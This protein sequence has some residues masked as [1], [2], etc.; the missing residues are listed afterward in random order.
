M[1]SHT[2]RFFISGGFDQVS[3]ETGADLL[4]L[5]DLDQKLWA[6]LS[7]PVK[8][9][10]FDLKTLEL[11]DSDHDGHIRAP[12][13][14]EAVTWA[15]SVLKDPE[16]LIKGS[17][18]IP[19]SAIN[20]KTDE[21]KGLLSSAQQ[22]LKNLGKED[23]DVISVEDTDSEER[24]FAQMRFNGDGV[25]TVKSAD[26]DAAGSVITDIID[27]L[28]ADTDRSGNPGVSQGKVEQFFAEIQ[29]YSEWQ[30]SSGNDAS[31]LIL[32][33]T[34]ESAFETLS[35]VRNKVNDYFTRCNLAK[36]D[37]RSAELL[38]PSD[39]DYQRIAPN[40]FSVSFESFALFPVAL[41][42]PDKPLPLLEEINPAW[43]EL[44][45][46]LKEDVVKPF[47]GDKT[48]LTVEEWD[49]INTHF[50]PYG[51]WRAAKPDTSVERLGTE[52]INEILNGDYKQLID[53]L[54]A[55]DKAFEPEAN[56]I[57]SVDKLV[58]YCRYLHTL[59]NNFVAFRDFYDHR[60]K[61][62]FQAGTLYLDG[63][64]CDLCVKVDDIGAHTALSSLSRVY[65]A[66]C[67]CT[68]CGGTDK[69]IVAAAFTAGDSDQLMVGRNGVF[70]DRKGQDWDATIVRII[71]HPISIK[72]A[73]WAP[74]KQA[75][76][77]IS[78]QL[79]KLAAA[80]SRASEDRMAVS[81]MQSGMQT[82]GGKP[83]VEKAFDAGRF[84]GIFAA[85][86]LAIGAIGTAIASIVTGLLRMAWWQLPL[87]IIGVMLLISCPS[88][89]IAWLKLKKR[90]LGPILDANGWAV[91]ARA[92]INIKFG[93]SL[94]E[95][96][97]LPEGAK[98][99]LADPYADKKKPWSLYI[100][101]ILLIIVC[102]IFW[103]CR[104]LATLFK[105]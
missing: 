43:I 93:T 18:G 30:K 59:I 97:K 88:M 71:E 29:A 64:S 65:L 79:M 55:R 26:D 46:R 96:A 99:S 28:D 105:P 25:I 41:V 57:S 35:A 6:A 87:V 32:G 82:A 38:N 91:N 104:Y 39:G 44:I 20:D 12:E 89:L 47:L 31:I 77:M 19:L 81:A 101:I 36:F 2:W 100:L 62:V 86:G 66:Y 102:I 3:I 80:R 8:D 48:S 10:E 5:Q 37:K 15:A 16:F 49:D 103:K 72:Q 98:K 92:K 75:G 68:R 85:I 54:I 67:N 24:I 51:A 14:I 69:M 4:S 70:Y 90:N 9:L 40:D 17:E 52:R 21:G 63:R 42:E 73:F 13:I 45:T 53:G 34:T 1:S 58:R 23:A 56:A 27:C 50:A 74:Y 94:T 95:T 83:P 22:I 11:V 7:C 78:E 84:A 60:S 33:D 76:R 61:A